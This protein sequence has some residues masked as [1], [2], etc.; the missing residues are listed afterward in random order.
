MLVAARSALRSA[1]AWLLALVQTCSGR[2]GA[3]GFKP[4]GRTVPAAW[5]SQFRSSCLYLGGPS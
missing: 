1:E 4:K 5:P 2:L 3:V